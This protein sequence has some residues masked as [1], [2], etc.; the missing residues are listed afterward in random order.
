MD[1]KSELTSYFGVSRNASCNGRIEIFSRGVLMTLS[2]MEMK[3][4]AKNS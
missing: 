3:L 1:F 2:N 4:S